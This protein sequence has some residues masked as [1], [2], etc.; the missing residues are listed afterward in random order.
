MRKSCGLGVIFSSPCLKYSTCSLFAETKTSRV[1]QGG[2]AQFGWD[3][4][5]PK[6]GKKIAS[7]YKSGI[8]AK[9]VLAEPED[10]CK[11]V[12]VLALPLILHR[13]QCRLF[14]KFFMFTILVPKTSYN[15]LIIQC[16]G[17]VLTMWVILVEVQKPTVWWKTECSELTKIWCQGKIAIMNPVYSLVLSLV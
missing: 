3:F 16:L 11:Q 14:P 17:L 13:S 8:R 6:E 10:A 4:N 15:V 2:S 7:Q 9:A 1:F 12:T 5:P